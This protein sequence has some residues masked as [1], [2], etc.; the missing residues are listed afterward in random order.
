MARLGLVLSGGSVQDL[1]T[2]LNSSDL[3]S[4]EKEA[5]NKESEMKKVP[6]D[7]LIQVKK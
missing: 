3:V 4:Y 2:S 1:N 6:D 5:Q 7:L